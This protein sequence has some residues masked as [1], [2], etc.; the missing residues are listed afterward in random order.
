MISTDADR[1][2]AGTE[3]FSQLLGNSP[4]SVF[5]RERVNGEI[6]KITDPPLFEGIDLQ[7]RI[8]GPDHGRLHA[9]VSRAEARTWAVGCA[10]VEWNADQGKVEFNCSRNMWQPHKCGHAG[11]TWID[12][13]IDRQGVRLCGSSFG[14]HEWRAL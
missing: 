14:F 8:P 7:L 3:H 1:A 13:G 11:E 12:Q 5:N 10:S 4:I 6:A 2:C 9:N